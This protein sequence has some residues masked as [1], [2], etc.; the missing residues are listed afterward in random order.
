MTRCAPNSGLT[1]IR[2]TVVAFTSIITEKKPSIT[3]HQR[4]LLNVQR[5][6]RFA[7]TVRDCITHRGDDIKI[8]SPMGF[9][10]PC[11]TKTD[12]SGAIG[13][14]GNKWPSI[15]LENYR[16][17]SRR[18]FNVRIHWNNQCLNMNGQTLT[19]TTNKEIT[20]DQWQPQ[21]AAWGSE[22]NADL[23]KPLQIIILSAPWR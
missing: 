10:P 14:N 22:S 11:R 8:F 2:P 9:Y 15:L 18:G 4:G 20:F 5:E 17:E 23:R 21:G 13:R 6:W 12:L 3:Q 19:I 7:A 1:A 16:A